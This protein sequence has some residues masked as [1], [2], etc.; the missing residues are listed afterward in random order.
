MAGPARRLPHAH[1]I[2][3]R[4][5]QSLAQFHTKRRVPSVEI[6]DRVSTV[7]VERV[8]IGQHLLTSALLAILRLPALAEADEEGA[9]VLSAGGAIGI[10]GG[11][12]SRDVGD[13][14]A[15]RQ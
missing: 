4:Q 7:F 14:L 1:A 3:R 10:V 9:I 12:E 2:V 15:E 8:A 6:P 5:V 11:R 13:V